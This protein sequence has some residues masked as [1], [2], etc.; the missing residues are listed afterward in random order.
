MRDTIDWVYGRISHPNP[1][2]PS[3]PFLHCHM[4]LEFQAPRQ[5]LPYKYP[6]KCAAAE[7]DDDGGDSAAAVAAADDLRSSSSSSSVECEQ[8]EGMM[9]RKAQGRFYVST[10]GHAHLCGLVDTLMQDSRVEITTEHH[11]LHKSST[12]RPRRTMVIMM[13]MLASRCKRGVHWG[14]RRNL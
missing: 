10:H 8:G 1:I 6:M 2:N 12:H 14:N 11:T 7:G 3:V 4:A 5:S 13:M 9:M